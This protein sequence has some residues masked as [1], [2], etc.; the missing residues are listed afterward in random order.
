MRSASGYSQ[1]FEKQAVDDAEDGGG[2]ADAEREREDGDGCEG[3]RFGQH[4][5][6]VAQVLHQVAYGS[7]VPRVADRLFDLLDAAE[8]AER[9][10]AGLFRRQALRDELFG[11]R[12]DV[13]AQLVVQVVLDASTAEQRAQPEHDGIKASHG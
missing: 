7:H 13:E 10:G 1:R 4:A 8:G 12:L 3:W 6:A 11:V 5:H 2:G 9:R